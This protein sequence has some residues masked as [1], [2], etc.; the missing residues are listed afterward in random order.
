MTALKAAVA[1]GALQVFTASGATGG[2]RQ[3]T[4][5][6][7]D[8]GDVRLAAAGTAR[9]G[10]SAGNDVLDGGES[11]ADISGGAGDDVL[12]AGARGGAL[13]GGSGADVFVIN[14]AAGTVTV[15]G[16]TP[17]EDRL[18]LSLFEDLRSAA[19]LD[20]RGRSFGIEIE[21]GKPGSCWCRRA[22]AGWG[23]RRCSARPCSL[24]SRSGRTPA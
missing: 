12:V 20:A 4:L 23:W 21:A 15:R 11:G 2:I 22:A 3:F 6:L 24:P 19:Q 16:F 8:L 10:G 17:G 5:P 18:D 1:G 14:P 9:L 7:A 13:D